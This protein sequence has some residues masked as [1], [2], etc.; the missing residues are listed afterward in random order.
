[1][2]PERCWPLAVGVVWWTG[3]P[4]RRCGRGGEPELSHCRV[5]LG[6]FS[7]LA[8]GVPALILGWV[9]GPAGRRLIGMPRP[10]GRRPVMHGDSG[11][12]GSLLL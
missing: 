6:G 4:R 3:M 5:R 7:G 2:R 9:R 11:R 12:V 10:R 8:G 1:M